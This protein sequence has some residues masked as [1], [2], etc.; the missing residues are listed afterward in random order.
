VPIPNYAPGVVADAETLQTVY[1]AQQAETQRLTSAASARLARPELTVTG[2]VGVGRP[3]GTILEVADRVAPDLLVVGSR[4][5]GPLTAALLGSVSEELVDHA[6]CP[7]LVARGPAL[8]RVLLAED[9]SPDAQSASAL[10]LH[11]PIFRDAEV[12]VVSVA[13]RP[14]VYAT[15][16]ETQMTASRWVGQVA[17]QGAGE[18]ARTTA[19]RLSRGGLHA[20]TDV[21]QG[22]PTMEI[23]AAAADW[24]ADLVVIGTRGQTGLTRLLHGSVA[25]KVLQ[26]ARCSVLIERRRQTLPDRA[27]RTDAG[28]GTRRH[29][30]MVPSNAQRR[31]RDRARP[32]AGPHVAEAMSVQSPAGWWTSPEGGRQLVD[33]SLVRSPVGDTLR[34]CRKNVAEEPTDS[35]VSVRVARTTESRNRFKKGSSVKTDQQLQSDVEQ[36][37][38]WDPSVHD[39]ERIG[40]SVKSGVVELDGQVESLYA[41]WAA[42]RA[43]LRVSN[44]KA[45]AGELKVELP[46]SAMRT[47]A[48]IARAALNQLQW[49]HSVPD[50]VK[51]QVTN[52][53]V[54]LSGTTEWQY[55]KKAAENAVRPLKGVT[56]VVNEITVTPKL[57]A[58]GV[59]DRIEAALKRHAALDAAHITV[60]TSGGK[61]T[62]RGSVRS[63]AEREEAT[64]AAWAAPGVTA[65][66]DLITIR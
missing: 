60:E 37:L 45:V 28:D 27:A 10:L 24:P 35:S 49:H 64:Q 44:V 34:G 16:S 25:R 31:A 8:H 29:R 46:S 53:R 43:A 4:G 5:L 13:Q 21:R 66:E 59:K 40:V 61:V 7:V 39:P 32:A 19:E 62:L 33:K 41:K 50:T 51:V 20:D 12:R 52:G 18:L 65:V 47:D 14:D 30:A 6:P 54:T 36:E 63:W 2:E 26:H 38:R 11:W 17:L 23:L 56:W 55:Q 15:N 57:S 42:E 22:D 9:G 3:A 58:A 48:D 1:D